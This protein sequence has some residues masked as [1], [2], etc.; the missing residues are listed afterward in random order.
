MTYYYKYNILSPA[1]SEKEE[2]GMG[3]IP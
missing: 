3:A 2:N 1:V